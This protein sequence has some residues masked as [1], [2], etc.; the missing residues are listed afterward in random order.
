MTIRTLSPGVLVVY[1]PLFAC[2]YRIVKNRVFVTFLIALKNLFKKNSGKSPR[3]HLD[4]I[5]L[6]KKVK[7]LFKEIVTMWIGDLLLSGLKISRIV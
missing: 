1:I 4:V 7:R 6:R 5:R 2:E 3:G